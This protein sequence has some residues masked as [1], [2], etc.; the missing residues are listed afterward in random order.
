[1]S[2][3]LSQSI[4]TDHGEDKFQLRFMKEE[5]VGL[6]TTQSDRSYLLLD[7]LDY[8][9]DLIQMGYP[10]KKKCRCKN[11]WFMVRL[12]YLPREATP[13]YKNISV[14]TTCAH[15]S[16]VSTGMDLDI[17]YS[18]TDH[19]YRQP[20]TFCEKP[21]ISYQFS[22]LT[23]YWNSNNLKHFLTFIFDDL[24]LQVYCWFYKYPDGIRYFEKVTY[25][26]AFEIIT[27]NHQY[28]N[29]FF[30]IQEIDLSEMIAGTEE[31]GV[32]LKNDLW[33]KN[34]LVE[35]SSPTHILGY[36]LL[37]YIHYCGQHLDKG[38]VVDKSPAF[39]ALTN[40]LE[41][42]L[43]IHFITKRGKHCYDGEEAYEK[44][45]AKKRSV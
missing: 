30:S 36:G 21:K 25:Q 1:M 10:K 45:L 6:L 29:F 26:K 44:F 4:V 35:L 2:P 41:Q 11:E 39:R 3:P 28:L 37:F 9:Y 17:D 13:D 18:P 5:G 40:R 23:A 33:R 16:K 27:V 32:Y 20:I 22:Q 15:C 34:D 12:D 31:R 7:S 8:W 19:L 43:A 42:W 38:K 24:K 14:I